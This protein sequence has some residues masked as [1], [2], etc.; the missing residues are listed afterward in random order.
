MVALANA[1]SDI[2]I[3]PDSELIAVLYKEKAMIL[4]FNPKGALVAK[5]EDPQNGMSGMLWAPDSVQLLVFSELLFRVSIYNLAE[6][7][8]SYI[9]NP[10]LATARGCVFSSAGKLM[11]LL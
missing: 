11:A 10:K 3:S 7:N 4:V 8:I 9:R 5:I 6:K 2:A 1:P